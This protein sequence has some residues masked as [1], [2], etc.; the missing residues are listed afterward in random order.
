MSGFIVIAKGLEK[1]LTADDIV[2][3][4]ICVLI[5]SKLMKIATNIEFISMFMPEEEANGGLACLFTNFSVAYLYLM[6]LKPGSSIVTTL[7]LDDFP[8]PEL[9][10]RIPDTQYKGIVGPLS[11]LIEEAEKE[12]KKINPT[13]K[14]IIRYSAVFVLA[15]LIGVGIMG[16]VDI[17]RRI[18]N[19]RDDG[20][21]ENLKTIFGNIESYIEN[22]N[23]S[24]LRERGVVL[25]SPLV[26]NSIT[27]LDS[28]KAPGKNMSSLTWIIHSKPDDLE[29]K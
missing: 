4:F 17:F 27:T 5:R 18:L 2:S 15:G 1:I 28:A 13:K 14:N 11:N 29:S 26:S 8:S 25:L 16:I 21:P 24:Q 22:A 19:G 9:Y 10:E 23:N 20:F 7:V 12:I 6:K 3:F